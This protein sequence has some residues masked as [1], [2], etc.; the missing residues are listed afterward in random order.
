MADRSFQEMSRHQV[1]TT[2]GSLVGRDADLV[3]LREVLDRDDVRLLTLTGPGGV[4]KTRLALSLAA[5]VERDF[6]HGT[7]LISIAGTRNPGMLPAAVAEAL[8]I[9][10]SPGTAAVRA[11]TESLRDQH[12]L[13][14]MDNLE[15]LIEPAASLVEQVLIHSPRLKVLATS[16]APINLSIE[17]RWPVSPL[18]LEAGATRPP[19]RSAAFELFLQRAAQVRPDLEL[20][21]AQMATVVAICRR[22]DG[23]PLALELAAARLSAMSVGELLKQLE[24]SLSILAGGYRNAPARQRSMRDTIGWSYDLLGDDERRLLRLL[25]VFV[26]GFTLQAAEWVAADRLGDSMI[27]VLG[28]LVDH[29][30]VTRQESPHGSR[31]RMHESIR[32]YGIERLRA[33]S[34]EAVARDAHAAYCAD[35]AGRAEPGVRGPD[36]VRWLAETSA[37]LSNLRSATRW[38]IDTAR[39]DTA[40]LLNAD[41]QFVM[42]MRGLTAEGLD[43]MRTL[44]TH[45]AAASRPY[46]RGRALLTMG[47]YNLHAGERE[48]AQANLEE[49]LAVFRQCGDPLFVTFTLTILGSTLLAADDLE[50]VRLVAEEALGLARNHGL[51]RFQCGAL[52]GLAAVA[53]ANGDRERSRTLEEDAL[54]VARASGDTWQVAV[55]TA[56]LADWNVDANDISAAENLLQEALTALRTFGYTRDIPDVQTKLARIA[57]RRDDLT[58]AASLL[59]SALTT[60][61]RTGN[62]WLGAKIAQES[63]RVALARG[64]LPQAAALLKQGIRW[65]HRMGAIVGVT[66]CIDDLAAVAVAAGDASDATRLRGAVAALRERTDG[67]QLPDDATGSVAQPRRPVDA[68]PGDT[69]LKARAEDRHDPAIDEFLEL[70]IRYQPNPGRRSGDRPGNTSAE[71]GSLSPREMDVLRLMADGL[72]NPQISDALFVSRRTVTTHVASI[73]TKMNLASRTAA[74]A[75]AIR[76]GMV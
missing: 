2:L 31:F 40:I 5:A 37:E 22:L 71:Y 51:A 38:L 15:H 25:S 55:A 23:V 18:S 39:V 59:G 27:N 35:L 50:R 21:D 7:R 45:P 66:Q 69:F 9:D 30:L 34:E 41:I 20:D 10:V 36:Q 57:L 62:R 44:M 56:A 47:T 70:A 11:I 68:A 64:E 1:P 12:L 8:G 24:G 54:R 4:G 46:V 61:E 73:L 32:E 26:D 63:G 33:V 13:L 67:I 16:R 74:V 72:T 60:V 42:V 29:S 52:H 53:L 19:S 65:Y 6:A 49:A 28:A 75:Y 43:V 58:R 14:V 17:V 48:E 76:N 3:R